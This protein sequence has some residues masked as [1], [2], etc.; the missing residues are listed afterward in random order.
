MNTIIQERLQEVLAQSLKSGNH[1]MDENAFCVMEAVA[2][3]AG[4][5]WTDRPQC[6]SPVISAM[7]RSINDGLPDDASRNRLLKPF[8][9]KLVGSIASDA[10]EERRAAMAAD[11]Y[12]RTYVPTILDRKSVV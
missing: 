1:D 9:P 3:V 10:V 11:W 6:A 8:I 12:A 4:E 5:E 7:L 2:Y